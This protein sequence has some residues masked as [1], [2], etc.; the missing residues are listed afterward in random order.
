MPQNL[1]LMMIGL[2]QSRGFLERMT[3]SS[4]TELACQPTKGEAL[5]D[6]LFT[7]REGLVGE[8][9]VGGCLGYS[10]HEIIKFP[11]GTKLGG[12]STEHPHQTSAGQALA[13]SRN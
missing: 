10:G 13:Y 2:R 11:T 5:L 4:L 7:N 3:D 12:T 8:V 6:L 9:A 1:R